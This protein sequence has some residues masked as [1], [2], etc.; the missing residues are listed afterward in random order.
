MNRKRKRDPAA[1]CEEEEDQ[2]E[3]KTPPKPKSI[4]NGK[5]KT[6]GEGQNETD[7][8]DQNETDEEDEL[9]TEEEEELCHAETWRNMTEEER[10][11]H[12]KIRRRGN[13]VLFAN[14]QRRKDNLTIWTWHWK[15]QKKFC[16]GWFKRYWRD[17]KFG[18]DRHHNVYVTGEEQPGPVNE[19]AALTNR[20]KLPKE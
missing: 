12:R 4:Q 3:Y 14:L 1:G 5:D 20:P 10:D 15:T 2:E 18:G 17:H 11:R 16:R 7:E 9:D 6:D 13:E 19:L 8:E